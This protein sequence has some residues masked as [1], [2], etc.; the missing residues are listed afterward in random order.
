MENNRE[1]REEDDLEWFIV[2]NN[3]PVSSSSSSTPLPPPQNHQFDFP[4]SF[5]ANFAL[6]E[7]PPRRESVP[8]N[9][10]FQLSQPEFSPYHQIN[11]PRVNPSF[12]ELDTIYHPRTLLEID[13]NRLNLSTPSRHS[14]VPNGLSPVS[15][16]NL[17]RLRVE[18]A[19]RGQNGM[20]TFGAYPGEES[21]E[22]FG[23]HNLNSNS[24]SENYQNQYQNQYNQEQSERQNLVLGTNRYLPTTTT[25]TGA[26]TIQNGFRSDY[27][28]GYGRASS[29]N[30]IGGYGSYG[31]SSFNGIGGYAG[32]LGSSS[33][34]IGG[35]GGS[36]SNGN[37]YRAEANPYYDSNL[38]QQSRQRLNLV[39]LE[40]LRGR[41]VLAAMDQRGCRFLQKKFEAR[42]PEEIEMIFSEVKDHV[43][44]LMVHQFGNYFIQKFFEVCSQEQITQMLLLVVSDERQLINICGDMHGTRAM[45]KLL[46]YLITGE[47][48]SIIISVLRRITATLTKSL[49]GHHVI[50]HCLKFFS[51]EE[52]KHLLTVVAD[53]CLE[54]ATDKSGCC[55]LQ[56]C[57]LHAEGEPRERLLAEITGNALILAEHPYGN[58]V[59]QY[60]LGLRIPEVTAGILAQLVGS[61]VSLAMNKY[62]SNVVE[63]CLRE[64]GEDQ[65]S[66]IIREI[67]SSQNF[68]MVLQ[69]PY[70]NYVAQSALAISKMELFATPWLASFRCI[71]HSSIAIPMGRGSWH[72][73]EAASSAYKRC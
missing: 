29:S 57:V 8:E 6:Q 67:V 25:T 68:L 38:L 33:I 71:T 70:G 56:Q 12:L 41:I 44:E 54:I 66:R 7:N 21:L 55:V 17:Q 16:V 62:G 15:D 23:L 1:D 65:V 49:N 31:S 69:D 13:F 64:A 59:V 2:N 20:Y 46:N 72:V 30:E 36:S 18:S 63:K 24:V 32:Y 58:Y 34:G 26:Y 37:G 22:S 42:N 61:H 11:M 39:S 60:M 27:N 35:L 10:P 5:P 48:K 53:N 45:Q 14:P 52:I 9:H 43:R 19:V 51:S 47:Q 3:Q 28:M 50:Q 73:P 40:E 4:A